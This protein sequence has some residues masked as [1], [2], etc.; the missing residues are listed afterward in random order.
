MKAPVL[1][2][3]VPFVL[4]AA[5]LAQAPSGPTV[6]T[7]NRADAAHCHVIVVDSRPLL[8]TTWGGTSVA[9]G[10]PLNEG[11]GEFSIF[12]SVAQD[13]S[14]T[15]P[16]EVAPKRFSAVYSDPA[17]TRFSWFDKARDLDT[18]ASIRSAGLIP[19]GA[20]AGGPP[21]SGANADSSTA[22][23][24]PTHPEVMA[25]GAVRETNPGTRSEEEARQLQQR[26][27]AGP[28]SGPAHADPSKL[29]F[30]RSATVKPGAHVS[31]FVYFRKP[32]GFRLE[33]SSSGALDEIDIPVNG[34]T[35]RF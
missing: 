21:P 29:V 3:L 30:L 28:G 34:I 15:G 2:V 33:A 14:A 4:A 32:K 5:A 1:F 13:A 10:M 11:N 12:V 23:P 9:V 24:D 25:M 20:S 19:S 7:F 8:E 31:G 22:A 17:H 6:V 18:Q 27:Q 26:G 16:A 35:F